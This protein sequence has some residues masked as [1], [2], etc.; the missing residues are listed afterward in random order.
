[1]GYMYVTL[2]SRVRNPNFSQQVNNQR[3]TNITLYIIYE[4]NVIA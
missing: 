3:I 2:N 1:M 4:T